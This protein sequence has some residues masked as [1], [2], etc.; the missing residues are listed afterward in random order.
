MDQVL[1][2]CTA[3]QNSCF[4]VCI[5]KNS[6]QLG[7]LMGHFLGMFQVSYLSELFP[8]R[9]R[10]GWVYVLESRDLGRWLGHCSWQASYTQTHSAQGNC[11]CTAK[12]A[13]AESSVEAGINLTPGCSPKVQA[14]KVRLDR[15]Q[16]VKASLQRWEV[17]QSAIVASVDINGIVHLG[18]SAPSPWRREIPPRMR[19]WTV[20]I[21]SLA[22]TANEPISKAIFLDLKSLSLF[23][24]K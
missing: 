21:I 20:K 8:S 15:S 5:K 6:L 9:S 10:K 12:R 11:Y 19:D 7:Y 17:A 16:K 23:H 2:I 14:S 22:L 24:R 3:F 1:L 4:L 18:R 13:R